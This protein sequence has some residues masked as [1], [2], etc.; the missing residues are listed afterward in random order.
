VADP[1]QI[2]QVIMNLAVNA[3][4]AMRTGGTL[5]IETRNMYLDRD[6]VGQHLD[7][8][9][10]SYVRLTV[11]DT[12]EGMSEETQR[13]VFEPFFTTKEIGKGT[14][15]GLST[16]YGIVK[17]SGGDVMV[18]SELDHGTAFKVYLPAVDRRAFRRPLKGDLIE[19]HSGTETIL[20][21]EDDE[22]VRKLVREVLSASGYHILE[23]VNGLDA[24]SLSE[25][26]VGTIHL[27]LTDVIMPKMGGNE[28]KDQI[29]KT[30][31]DTKM[32]LMSGYPDESIAHSGIYY[33]DIAFIEKPFHPNILVKKVREVLES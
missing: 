18:Y 22:T 8:E 2:E 14:G 15:L 13:H 10:G 3:R 7:M 1:G 16:V 24:L 5:T 23:A 33:A 17:Q 28:L 21:V 29:G 27:L 26:Y 9:P 12:G 11:A 32:L 25:R 30:R 6:Y 19:K 20:L 31:P 4:D